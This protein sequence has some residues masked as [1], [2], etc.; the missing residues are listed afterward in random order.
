M[1]RMIIEPWS[2]IKLQ[3]FI[4]RRKW[5]QSDADLE[6]DNRMKFQ[7]RRRKRTK[8]SVIKMFRGLKVSNRSSQS[9][10]E[11]EGNEN[12]NFDD[13]NHERTQAYV[14]T[15]ILRLRQQ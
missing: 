13:D 4:L 6:S 11:K 15:A 7:R 14:Q 9:S 12:D 10:P 5:R 1:S 8:S 2:Y 3:Y